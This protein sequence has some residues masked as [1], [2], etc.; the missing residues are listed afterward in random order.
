MKGSIGILGGAGPMAGIH[1]K[2][3]FLRGV[4]NFSQG[5]RNPKSWSY[6]LLLEACCLAAPK[7]K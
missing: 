1:S 7:S 2:N 3:F 5:L 4:S 6:F